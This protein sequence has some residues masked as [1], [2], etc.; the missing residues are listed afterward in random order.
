MNIE[1]LNE[2]IRGQDGIINQIAAIKG[3][4]N[5]LHTLQQQQQQQ[6]IQQGQAVQQQQ[7][8]QLQQAQANQQQQQQQEKEMGERA[9]EHKGIHQQ[10][11]DTAN[12]TAK[13]MKHMEDINKDLGSVMAKVEEAM[14]EAMKAA[15]EAQ[16]ASMDMQDERS[17]RHHR[18]APDPDAVGLA[19][20]LESLASKTPQANS[21]FSGDHKGAG[22]RQW[23]KDLY[24][25]ATW[26]TEILEGAMKRSERR[27]DPITEQDLLEWGVEPRMD[28]ALLKAIHAW[29]TPG[30]IARLFVGNIRER[31]PDTTG[32]EIWRQL[33][34]EF[35]PMN[36]KQSQQDRGEIMKGDPSRTWT[37]FRQK[38]LGWESKVLEY[39]KRVPSELWTPDA[40]KCRLVFEMIPPSKR[41]IHP[42]L[43]DFSVYSEL[44]KSLDPIAER[45]R[46]EEPDRN[47][48][49]INM[50]ASFASSCG[51]AGCKEHHSPPPLPEGEFPDGT[52]VLFAVPG[53]KP[54]RYGTLSGKN[55]RW[56]QA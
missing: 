20:R 4:V 37:E 31:T 48:S 23:I 10:L 17:A 40:D 16:A 32:L 50:V 5:N 54:T 36:I 43:A 24:E 35:D 2:I 14:H 9:A 28:S 25:E 53:G 1:Q 26:A 6:Q 33:I 34:H 12:D 46:G 49:R 19:K 18:R 42:Q 29:T 8:Q 3:Q 7:Q 27:K 47:H 52:Q 39:E 41:E 55:G 51:T 15:K 30:S 11:Q 13:T 56:A 22:L 45:G 21:T 38:H 44:K